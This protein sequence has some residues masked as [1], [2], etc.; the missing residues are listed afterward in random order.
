MTALMPIAA[1][2]LIIWFLSR[3]PLQ[4]ERLALLRARRNSG[5]APSQPAAASA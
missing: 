5:A 2:A 3:Y 4:G 1:S